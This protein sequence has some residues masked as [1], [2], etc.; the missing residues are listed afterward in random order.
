MPRKPLLTD[1]FA[2]WFIGTPSNANCVVTNKQTCFILKLLDVIRSGRMFNVKLCYYDKR[3]NYNE[4]QYRTVEDS[5]V[6][7]DC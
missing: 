2:A 6:L 5:E 1:L 3:G 7:T 4:T